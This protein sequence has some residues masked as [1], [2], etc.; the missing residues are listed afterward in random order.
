MCKLYMQTISSIFTDVSLL[1][2]ECDRIINATVDGDIQVVSSLITDNVDMNA[3][4]HEVCT[5]I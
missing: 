1:Q 3:V 4:V 5:Y 2:E